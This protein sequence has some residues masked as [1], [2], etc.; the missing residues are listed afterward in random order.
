MPATYR[1]HVV[2]VDRDDWAMALAAAVAAEVAAIG[3]HKSVSVEVGP[4]PPHGEPAVAVYLGSEVAASD[5]TCTAAVAE[6]LAKALTVVPVVDH[7]ATFADHVPASLRPINGWQWSGPDAPVRLARFLLEELGIEERQRSVFI[8]HKREDGLYAAEQLYDHLGHHGFKPFIDRFDLRAAA[9]VQ[10]Q[11]ADAL[12]ARAFLLLLETPLAHTSDWVFDEV[13]YAL[14]HTMGMHIVR[15]PGAVVDVPGS[16][17]L[18]RQTLASDG[19]TTVKGYDALTVSG[20]DGVLA[21]V[22]AAHATALVR[23]RR[24][25]LRNVEDAAEAVGR[26][27]TPLPGWRLLVESAGGHDVVAVTGRLPTVE[28]LYVLDA[29]RLELT[30]S[31][32]N[33]TAV[34]VHSARRLDGHRRSILDWATGPRPV[35]L[36]PENAIGGYW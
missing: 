30:A 20:L 2:H 15:W 31:V 16:S 35:T 14:T 26:S 24:Q 13:D 5:A 34:L 1:I 10:A 7:L 6:A 19:L 36:V 3:L 11:I 33:P 28:D 17:R 4:A 9:D 8:S 22:E 23:R 27:C 29:V 25:L 12:E 21:E 32:A 18:P